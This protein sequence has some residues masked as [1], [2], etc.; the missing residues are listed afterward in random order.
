MN[1]QYSSDVRNEKM[2]QTYDQ[3][4]DQGRFKVNL[5]A[6]SPFDKYKMSLASY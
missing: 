4:H 3:T 1:S 6:N 5:S 2:D